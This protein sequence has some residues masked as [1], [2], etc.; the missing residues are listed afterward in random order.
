MERLELALVLCLASA[1]AHAEGVLREAKLALETCGI[2]PG[3]AVL[4][5]LEQ[6]GAARCP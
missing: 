1:A 6:V 5:A 3:L 4:Q 2:K